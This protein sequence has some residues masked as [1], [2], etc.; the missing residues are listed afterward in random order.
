M[1][2]LCQ[3]KNALGIPGKGIH[4]I[5][6]FNIAIVDVILTFLLALIISYLM[7]YTY[8]KVLLAVFILG[9]FLHWVFCVDTT[10]NRVL[11]LT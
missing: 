8:W 6:I 9:I 4:S 7:G 11:G 1:T 5:R 10:V 2:R 3:Y